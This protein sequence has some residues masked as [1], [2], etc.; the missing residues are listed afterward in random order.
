[1]I[2]L[3]FIFEGFGLSVRFA[4]GIGREIRSAELPIL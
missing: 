3:F 1:M 4:G 2:F